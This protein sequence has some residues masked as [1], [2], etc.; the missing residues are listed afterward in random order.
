[1]FIYQSGVEFSSK[2]NEIGSNAVSLVSFMQIRFKNPFLQLTP[3][4]SDLL[5]QNILPI[6]I[7][8]H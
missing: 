8:F 7:L 2:F 6:Q 5:G 4:S 3:V 1:M